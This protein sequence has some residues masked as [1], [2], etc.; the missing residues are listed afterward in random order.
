M[1]RDLSL[2][3]E[4]WQE[5]LLK[6]PR[7]KFCLDNYF[8]VIDLTEEEK[9]DIGN[10]KIEDDILGYR[11]IS[12]I[13]GVLGGRPPERLW[14]EDYKGLACALG[15]ASVYFSFKGHSFKPTV[16]YKLGGLRICLNDNVK[17]YDLEAAVDFFGLSVEE[18]EW[19]FLSN[20][21]R[22]NTNYYELNQI[23]KIED[24]CLRVQKFLEL[25]GLTLEEE[26]SLY[27]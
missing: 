21:Y 23:G 27:F 25:E 22:R 8:S 10:L 19:L 4:L 24:V 20:N 17:K 11:Y 5:V 14:S 2:L 6:V 18:A 13:K 9:K 26:C 7:E 15:W 1:K 16:N 3:K 12:F